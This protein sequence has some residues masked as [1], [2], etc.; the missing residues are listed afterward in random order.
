MNPR[1]LVAS[2]SAAAS[3]LYMARE[4]NNQL[5]SPSHNAHVHRFRLPEDTVSLRG[6]DAPQRRCGTGKVEMWRRSYQMEMGP[7]PKAAC[8]RPVREDY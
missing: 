5:H 2:F 8:R 3:I 4:A 6:P 1:L 7:H